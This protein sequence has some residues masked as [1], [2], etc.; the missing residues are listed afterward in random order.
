MT[1]YIRN[2][3]FLLSVRNFLVRPRLGD[4]RDLGRTRGVT[5]GEI[6]RSRSGHARRM[7]LALTRLARPLIFWHISGGGAAAPLRA[8][9]EAL[10]TSGRA[11]SNFHKRLGGDRAI[12]GQL[13][14]GGVRHAPRRGLFYQESPLN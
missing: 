5:R 14:G 10:P 6:E 2:D 8:N 9:P 4:E 12:G 3:M 13:R 7:K 1:F 11:K